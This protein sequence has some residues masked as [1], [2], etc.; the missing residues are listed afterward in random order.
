MNSCMK[1]FGVIAVMIVGS[2]A[3][4]HVR[5]ERHGERC[6]NNAQK[7]RSSFEAS[8]PKHGVA[9]IRSKIGQAEQLC[10]EQHDYANRM[11][12]NTAAICV[13]QNGC[14]QYRN[15]VSSQPVFR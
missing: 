10:L 2:L 15:K 11:L 8:Q 9:M 5:M 13:L 7:L 6:L 3:A 4:Q 1:A 14:R 12:N